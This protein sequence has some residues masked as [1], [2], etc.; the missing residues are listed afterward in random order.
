M[1]ISMVFDTIA[2]V[3]RRRIDPLRV[4]SLQPHRIFTY[5]PQKISSYR[6]SEFYAKRRYGV[7][8][9]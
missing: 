6:N 1:N 3:E 2:A 9:G 8:E 5:V 4:H 7:L